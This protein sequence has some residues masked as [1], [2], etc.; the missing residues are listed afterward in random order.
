ME[1][2]QLPVQAAFPRIAT[3]RRVACLANEEHCDKSPQTSPFCDSDESD[4]QVTWG[5][6]TPQSQPKK[7]I[8][9]FDRQFKL[10][11]H[12]ECD[13]L[14]P[15]VIPPLEGFGWESDGA[16]NRDSHELWDSIW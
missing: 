9:I 1:I 2:R 4:A 7:K 5:M 10:P 15:L 14:N 13:C 8:N 11:F 3:K 12:F 16:D 6:T